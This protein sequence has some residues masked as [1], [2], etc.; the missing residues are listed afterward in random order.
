M[1]DFTKNV[2]KILFIFV[3][4]HFNKS[5]KTFLRNFKMTSFY[6][7]LR[8]ITKIPVTVP[9]LWNWIILEWSLSFKEDVFYKEKMSSILCW[10]YMFSYESI[11]HRD[12]L[13]FHRIWT[14]LY[15]NFDLIKYVM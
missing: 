4:Y 13:I 8:K 1:N 2:S 11:E 7:I 15:V 12:K 10:F 6:V 14:Y 3:I 5:D 9:A